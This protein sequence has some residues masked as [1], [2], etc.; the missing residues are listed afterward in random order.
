METLTKILN[1]AVELFRPY[2][3]KTITMDDI[4]RKAGISKKTLYQHFAN[5]NEVVTECVLWYKGKMHELCCTAMEE[6]ENAVEAMVRI[7]GMFDNVNR[8]MNPIAMLELERF[9]PEA[10]Q[11]FREALIENDVEA[12]RENMERGIEEGLYRVDID[13]D[14]MAKYRMELSLIMFHNSLLVNERRDLQ[15]VGHQISEHFLYGIMTPKGEKLY[16]KYKEKYLK[17]VSKI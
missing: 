17:Q 7:M 11:K 14:F 15:F 2:G 6:S 12:I 3:F 8:Q 4:A 13:P 1:A 5:K 10:Y 9:F 16:Q